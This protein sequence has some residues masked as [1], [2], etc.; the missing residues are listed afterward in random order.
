MSFLVPIRVSQ[1]ADKLS[2]QMRKKRR[3]FRFI[4][5]VKCDY[6]NNLNQRLNFTTRGKKEISSFRSTMTKKKKSIGL[7]T[8]SLF[9]TLSQSPPSMRI[10]F[11]FA[12]AFFIRIISRLEFFAQRRTQNDSEALFFFHCTYSHMN[13]SKSNTYSGFFF[14]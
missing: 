11:F 14:L 2:I 5:Y 7:Q 10:S 4:F 6:F 9:F 8:D 1:T 13:I 3:N 12:V